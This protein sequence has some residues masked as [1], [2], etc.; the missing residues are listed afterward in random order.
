M[1]SRKKTSYTP[2]KANR[3]KASISK[4]KYKTLKNKQLKRVIKKKTTPK[5]KQSQAENNK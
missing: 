2:R 5:I 1:P 3:S 4:N